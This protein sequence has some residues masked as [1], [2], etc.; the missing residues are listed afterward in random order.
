[1]E[2]VTLRMLAVKIEPFGGDETEDF[3]NDRLSQ[4]QGAGQNGRWFAAD[5][6]GE[7]GHARNLQSDG[8]VVGRGD[9]CATVAPNRPEIRSNKACR[10][11]PVPAGNPGGC[12]QKGRTVRIRSHGAV[13]PPFDNP[14][15]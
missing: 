2:L 15:T 10:S 4:A 11:T 7:A 14:S 5:Q 8:I 9:I 1:M 12:Q 3:R 13:E 6:Y